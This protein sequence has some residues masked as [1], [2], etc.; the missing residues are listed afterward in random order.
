MQF[1]CGIDYAE[2]SQEA[3]CVVFQGVSIP[4]VSAPMLL[5]M[6]QTPREKDALD[7]QFLEMKIARGRGD[8]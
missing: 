7:R 6:K 1:A 5:R 3:E 2:A 8:V 4:F